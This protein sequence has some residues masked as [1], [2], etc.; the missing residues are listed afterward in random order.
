VSFEV[1][2]AEPKGRLLL[3]NARIVTMKGDEVLERG[4]LLV[5]NGR[6]AAVGRAGQGQSPS[7]V[8]TIDLTGKTIIPGFIDLH[9]HYIL[10][11][12]QWQGD[13]HFEQDPYLL[14]N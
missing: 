11:A 8:T 1:P 3:K 14:A 5:S 4:D 12:S 7:G 13:L 10:D 2:R 6:I 9:A